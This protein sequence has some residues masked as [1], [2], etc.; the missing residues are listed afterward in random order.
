MVG[1]DDS[2]KTSIVHQLKRRTPGY[3]EATHPSIGTALFGPQLWSYINS[4]GLDIHFYTFSFAKVTIWE[5]G[6]SALQRPI[7]RSCM[8]LPFSSLIYSNQGTLSHIYDIVL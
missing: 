2:G 3:L 7:W 6:G 5:A 1:L 8:Y 4:I